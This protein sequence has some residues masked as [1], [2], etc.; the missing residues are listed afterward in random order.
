MDKQT[1]EQ[2]F[3]KIIAN[4]SAKNYSPDRVALIFQE[5]RHLAVA[6][7]E[8]LINHMIGNNRYPPLVSDFRKAIA[9][10]NIKAQP[11]ND[12]IETTF[13]APKQEENYH[14]HLKDHY[15]AD[16]TH[17]HVRGKTLRECG[18]VI[19]ND[20][21]GNPLVIEDCNVR[22]SKIKECRLHLSKGTFPK[23][24]QDKSNEMR[25]VRY[26][27]FSPEPV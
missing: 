21:P 17:I 15:W 6:D 8:R 12:Y 26:D 24:D 23:F 19:K 16:N 9:E 13:S 25:R 20:H 11:R 7:F 14:Y 5:V 22:E 3:M 18:F 1:F 27:D 10:L 4:F 2:R